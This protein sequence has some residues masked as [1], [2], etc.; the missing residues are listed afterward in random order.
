M[1]C[2]QTQVLTPAPLAN[3]TIVD[4]EAGLSAAGYTVLPVAFVNVAGRGVTALRQM[5]SPAG[6]RVYYGQTDSGT[7]ITADLD[8]EAATAVAIVCTYRAR[9]V[10]E[11]AARRAGLRVTTRGNRITL[12]ARGKR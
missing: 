8:S 6:Q 12:T 7:L 9:V 2:F 4:I 3:A 10:V 1:P 5:Q 11:A